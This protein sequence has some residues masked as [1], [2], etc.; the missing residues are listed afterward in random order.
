[1]ATGV[2]TASTPKNVQLLD[3]SATTSGGGE[4]F[5]ESN[6]EERK[7]II[8]GLL[9]EGQLVAFAGPFGVGKSPM[10]AD[11]VMHVLHGIPWCDRRV[12]SRPVIHFDLETPGRVYKAILRNRAGCLG[13]SLP[14]VPEELLVYLEHDD[15]KEPATAKLLAALG[16]SGHE[17]CLALIAKGLQE[18]PNAL[19][20][21]DPLE[22]LFR[23]DTGKKKDVLRLYGELRHLLALHPQA[24]MIITFNLRKRDKK[25]GQSNLLADPRS[26][27]EEVCGTLDILN[28]SD[29]RVGIDLQGEDVRVI[30]GVR[31]GEEMHPSLIHPV[32][33]NDKLAGFEL[34]PPD[35]MALKTVLTPKQLDYWN[36][37]PSKFRFEEVADKSVPRGTLSR[38]LARSKSLGSIVQDGVVWQK[39]VPG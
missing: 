29:V 28:R 33:Y 32:S 27:L 30:N 16:Q 15:A 9:R 4:N 7:E 12:A 3:G 5:F 21:V 14:K 39:V 31:R 11:L 20:V 35:V 36:K 22:L 17:S 2:E 18:K 25:V 19:V 34:C 8:E 6:S 38:L 23:I 26:W 1:M 13:L 24:A 10:L 37:L